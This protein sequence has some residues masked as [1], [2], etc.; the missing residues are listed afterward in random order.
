MRFKKSY[1][2]VEN[3]LAAKDREIVRL[4]SRDGPQSDPPSY[5]P[6]SKDLPVV[7][8][9]L[10]ALN[11]LSVL[12]PRERRFPEV[13]VKFATALH[14]ISARSYQLLREV[15]PF[16]SA[17]RLQDSTRPDNTFII[18][19]L[20]EETGSEVLPAHLQE[21]RKRNKIPDDEQVRCTLAFEAT[22][23][24]A[25]GLPGKET[26]SGSS[27]AFMTLPLVSRRPVLLVRS[28]AR[29]SGKINDN[30]LRTKDDLGQRWLQVVSHVL[31]RVL[32]VCRE[33]R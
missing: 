24:T 14:A 18:S 16:P 2:Q 15:L 9:I 11:H 28:I 12:A 21:C 23:L 8:H 29:L 19:A 32:M 17:R 3:A 20:D 7:Q 25:T 13:V 22:S 30:I 31:S 33:R 5:S 26:D 1:K 6:P 10:L 4:M 27:F